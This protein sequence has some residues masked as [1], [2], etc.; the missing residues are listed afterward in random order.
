MPVFR[1]LLAILLFAQLTTLPLGAQR[2]AFKDYGENDGLNSLTVNCMLQDHTGLLWVGTENGL[3]VFDGLTYT[4]LGAAQGLDDSYI[5]SIHEDAAGDLWV[6]T[7]NNLYREVSGRFS[8]VPLQSGRVPGSPGQQLDSLDPEHILAVSH[9]RLLQIHRTPSNLKWTVTPFFSQALLKAHP[10]LEDTFGVYVARDR[11]VW[12]GCSDA[13]CQVSSDRVKV[14]S[15]SEGVGQDTW[16]WFLEDSAGRLWARGYHHIVELSPQ[17][18]HFQS[19]DILSTPVTFSS[20]FVPLAEDRSHRILTRTDQGLAIWSHGHWRTVGSANGMTAPGIRTLVVDANGGLWIGTYGKGVERWLGYDNWETWGTGQGLDH[21]PVW[22]MVRD[23]A[24]TLWAATESGIVRLN[25]SKARFERWHPSPAVP[26]GQVV[27]AQ[28]SRDRSLWFASTSG[29][30]LRYDPRT[31]EM[32][33]WKMPESI[34]QIWVD[35]SGTAWGLTGNGLYFASPASKEVSKVKNPAVPDALFSDVCEDA[36]HGLW[37]ASKA[38]IIHFARGKWSRVEVRGLDASDGYM[39][40]ACAPDGTLWLGGASTGIAHLRVP[41]NVATVADPAPPAVLNSVEVMFVRLDRRG[42]LWIGSG[43][44]VYV[45]NGARWRHITEKDGLA[46]NDCNEGAFLDDADGS[47]WIGTSNGLSHLLHPEELFQQHPLH[48]IDVSATLGNAA[49]PL[50]AS[51]TFAWTR[52]PLRVHIASSAFEDQSSTVYQYRLA[53]LDR[54]WITTKNPELYY[55]SLPDGDYRLQLYAEDLTENVRSPETVLAFRVRPPWWKGILF[56]TSAAV[57]V[58]LLIFV[59]LRYRERTMMA[60]QSR[61]E[62]LV[63]KRTSELE[64]EKQQLMEAREALREQATRDALTGLFNH[65]AIRDTLLREFERRRRE[66]T[67]VTVVM[68]DIDHFKSVNDLHGHLAGDKVLGELARRLTASIRIYDAAGRY[69]G[70][71]F[72]LIMPDYDASRSPDRVR[73]VHAAICQEPVPISGGQVSITCSFGVS[74]LAGN[75]AATAEELLDR[76]DKALYKAKELGRNRVEFDVCNDT[77][78]RGR[79]TELA[80]MAG[81]PNDPATVE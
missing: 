64:L 65:A 21:N 23:D 42:W 59:L 46:W 11:S 73:R 10:Q 39:G 5:L 63:R 55:P 3:Y 80:I 8:V 69:G 4:R 53:G 28:E 81:T 34:R 70:E 7:A 26:R 52:A 60:R 74:V 18:T 24:G 9:H 14:W 54:D 29:R 48:I 37:F 75:D 45:F 41:G 12:L 1:L 6:G 62:A 51:P 72:L 47:V 31:D 77:S 68:M 25:P 30:M 57:A 43:S 78:V 2:Y 22:S 50:N 36:R 56:E 71:E 13:V 20:T 49:I 61:L 19:E 79:S 33:Q 38:G 17:A 58:C 76:A 16:S 32:R 66:G 67:A 27:T 35:S 40:V 15:Q 44:G